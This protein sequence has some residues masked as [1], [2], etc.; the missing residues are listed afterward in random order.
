MYSDAVREI[1]E[2]EV[3]GTGVGAAA[4]SCVFDTWKYWHPSNIS[5]HGKLC[6]EI[7]REWVTSTDFSSRA[8]GDIFAGPRWLRNTFTWGG[9]TYP[10]YWCEAV[11]KQNLDCGTLAALAHEVFT[12]RGVWPALADAFGMPVGALVPASL[13]ETMP[14]READWAA[15]C[16]RFEL[17]AP[18]SFDR[19]VGQGF[20]YADVFLGAPAGTTLVS[21]VKVRQAGFGDCVDTEDMFRRLVGRLQERRLLPPRGW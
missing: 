17:A 10:I 7:A 12:M 20:V 9:S 13:A 4:G 1:A 5:H 21:T 2:M 15:L 16:K 6:C 14:P 19:F 3:I 11:R 18:T 8:G